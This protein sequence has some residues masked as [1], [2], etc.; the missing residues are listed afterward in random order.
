MRDSDNTLND[1]HAITPFNLANLNNARSQY[2]ENRH[3]VGL[4]KVELFRNLG[5]KRL[6][7]AGAKR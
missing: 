4:A 1:K 6:G 7:D 5:Q 3:L 2:G